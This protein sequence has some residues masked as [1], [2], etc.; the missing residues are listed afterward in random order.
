L[1]LPL[2]AAL[3]DVN[4]SRARR[5]SRRFTTLQSPTLIRWARVPFFA[6]MLERLL[7]NGVKTIIV[8]RPAPVRSRSHGALT[9]TIC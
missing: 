5:A 7:A 2:V 4:V 3:V 8:E 6:E 9:G 1:S